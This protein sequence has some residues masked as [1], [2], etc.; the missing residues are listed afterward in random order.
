MRDD[1]ERDLLGELLRL[2]RV[3][4]VDRA[5]LVEQFVHRGMARPGNRLVGR[6]DHPLDPGEVVQR[7]QRHDHLDRRAVRVGDDAA[8]GA[9]RDRL[10]IDLGH[11]QRHIRLHAEARGVVDDYGAGLCRTRRKHLRHLGARRRE[12]DVDAAEIVSVEALDLEDVVLA[13][14]DLAADR[15]RRGQRHD[16]VGGKL[17]LG[18]GGQ[19]LASDIAGRA[20]HRYPETHLETPRAK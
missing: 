18:E 1:V 16:V 11:D 6:D 12:H 10:R 13:K 5:G 3:V 19:D 7:L 14:R 9:L 2:H 15:A 4:D 8:L 20:D 17:A